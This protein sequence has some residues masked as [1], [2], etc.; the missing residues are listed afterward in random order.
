[1]SSKESTGASFGAATLLDVAERAGVSRATASLVVRDTGRVSTATRERVR[2]AMSELGYVY[3]RAAAAMRSHSTRSIGVIVTHVGNPFFAELIGGFQE[4][5]QSLGYSCILTTSGDDV[6]QQQRALDELR[7][8]KVAAVAFAPAT[9]TGAEFTANLEHLE[10]P[11]VMMTRQIR[12]NDPVPYVGPDDVAG[13]RLAAEH[14]LSHGART[15]A[16][17]GGASTVQSRADRR[18]GL[19]EAMSAAGLDTASVIDITSETSGRGGLRAAEQMLT[20]HDMPD[21]IM[22]HSDSVAFGVY[23]ALRIRDLAASV[24]VTGYDD[25]ATA[26]LW[27]P[28]LTTV[29]THP[30]ALGQRAARHLIDQLENDTNA[31]FLRVLPTLR[32]RQSCGCSAVLARDKETL[33]QTG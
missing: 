13:G 19:A 30:A 33:V 20:Q 31:G 16:Y 32:V 11:F 15:F 5:L 23:R 18:A 2:R 1:M 6:Q 12:D 27:E 24:R 14:L 22:C 21:A 3:D 9:G 28:P 8:H 29:A 4:E 26:E 7:S 17:L 10:L 25:I